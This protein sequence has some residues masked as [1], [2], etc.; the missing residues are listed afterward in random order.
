MRKSIRIHMRLALLFLIITTA[1]P[2]F[3]AGAF[4]DKSFSVSKVGQIVSHQ[5]NIFSVVAPEAG[6]LSVRIYDQ[7][8]EYRILSFD[9]PAGES[10]VKWDGC[11]YNQEKLNVGVYGFSCKLL[12]QSGNEYVC[13]FNA[14]VVN[15]AQYLQF[16]LP[17]AEAVYL[18]SPDEW[19]IEL[20]TILDGKVI[21]EFQKANTDQT[22]LS[23]RKTMH[24]RRVEHFTFSQIAGKKPP[25]PGLYTVVVYEISA[26]DHFCSFQLRICEGEMPAEAI[27]VTGDIM[28]SEDADDETL[29]K[30]IQEPVVVVNIDYLKHMNVL[31]SPDQ[32][33]EVL[34]TLHGQTQCLSVFEIRDNWAKIGAWNH[35]DASYIEGWVPL[36]S[37]KVVYPSKEYGLILNKSNQTLSIYYHGEKIETLLVS[38][39][40]MAENKYIRET[41]AGCFVTGLHRVDFSMQGSRYDFVIQYDGGNLLHQIP[42]SSAGIKDY[43]RGKPYLGAKASHAC[44]RIQDE[45]GLQSGINAYWLWTHLPYHTKMII[46]DDK[47]EREKE[48]AVLDG[49]VPYLE[50]SF[51]LVGADYSSS[52][53]AKNSVVISF[54]GVTIPGDPEGRQGRSNSFK[55]KIEQYGTEYPLSG[56]SDLFSQDDLTCLDLSC[57]LKETEKSADSKR[58]IL[59]R[60]LPDYAR[61]FS[62]SSVEMINLVN[63]HISD[64]K[65][66]GYLSTFNA[67]SNIPEIIGM[68]RMTVTEIEDILFGFVSFTEEAYIE[69][70]HIIEQDVESMQDKG[71]KYIICLCSWGNAADVHHTNLQNAMAR[72]CVRAG[73]D[74]VVGLRPDSPQGIDYINGTPVIYSLG[75]LLTGESDSLK[76]Y[77]A[78]IIRAYFSKDTEKQCPRLQLIPVLSSSSADQKKN[79]YRPAVA[80]SED[81]ERILDTIQADSPFQIRVK[82]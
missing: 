8:H 52:P 22:V 4:E 82:H 72:A 70:Y 11:S 73:A 36:D 32:K 57:V 60:G 74:L 33:K 45:P 39:G 28:P 48:M 9:V 49:R 20:K 25:E 41:S 10:I 56:L 65:E 2:F 15:N 51:S 46:F 40:R 21:I 62:D 7:Y 12:G 1:V 34:G 23:V 69:N 53:E 81:Y 27:P 47:E 29:W 80:Q 5:N 55:K 61:V 67:L 3:M 31:A 50:N 17:S 77:D 58:K 64:Y 14:R 54:G 75:R 24:R 44:V 66:E 35:E 78:L 43:S 76:S 30:K 13:S 42:Y 38:T 71:C 68:E 63:E 6:S 19:F 26:P 18:D 59:Y 79:D 16:V 37:L